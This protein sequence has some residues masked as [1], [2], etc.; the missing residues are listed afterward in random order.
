[1]QFRDRVA[2]MAV[3]T[4]ASTLSTEDLRES[5]TDSTFDL[6]V[7]E[8]QSFGNRNR[9]I[10]ERLRIVPVGL[11]RTQSSPLPRR[12]RRKWAL[13]RLDTSADSDTSEP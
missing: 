12:P 10:A 6:R 9:S 2:K 7:I 1:M 4:T 5:S 11:A 8:S 3:V 13:S